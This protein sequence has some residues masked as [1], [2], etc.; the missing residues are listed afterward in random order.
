MAG[1][2]DTIVSDEIKEMYPTGVWKDMLNK[3]ATYWKELKKT[4]RKA[5]EGLVKWPARTAA[6]WNIGMVDD[7]TDMP[8]SKDPVR[9]KFEL[10]PEIFAGSIQVGFKT[11]AAAKSGKSTFDDGGTV[12]D[13]IEGTAEDVAKY[14]NRVYA[15]SVIGRLGVVE[16]DGSNSV[17]LSK[18]LGTRLLDDQMVIEIR[19]ALTGGAVRDSISNRQIS[20]V[21]KDLRTFTYAGADQTAVAGDHVFIYGSYARSPYSLHHIVDDGSDS[22]DAVFGLARTT[23][24]KIKAQ[25][26]ANGGV[27]RNVTEQLI[28][29][30]IDRPQD[31]VGKRITKALCGPGQYRKIAEFVHADRRYPGAT[32][33]D[34]KY[35]VG[36]GKGAFDLLGPD[37]DCTLQV[38]RDVRPRS[39]YF[40]AWDL[41]WRYEA[42]ELDWADEDTLLK[43]VPSSGTHKTAYNAYICAIENQG[44][45][46]PSANS[47]LDDLKDDL[48]GDA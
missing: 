48:A 24:P 34:P 6:Q 1:S 2:F 11:R 22:P 28:L 30:A 17:T 16:A 40:L 31:R 14:M 5:S 46:M 27:L 23:Y 13:R 10:K 36:V 41:F 29:Q 21:D 4:D 38:E 20:A 9:K 44:C 33:N 19:D 8:A 15:G 7:N 26:L 32:T 18:P 25:I 12:S 39:I 42:Q 47:R 35:K 45:D 37:T 43:L 3:E